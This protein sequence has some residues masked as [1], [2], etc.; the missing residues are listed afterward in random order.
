MSEFAFVHNRW[1]FQRVLDG[2]MDAL[3]ISARAVA[4]KC[5]VSSSTVNRWRRGD[6][7]PDVYMREIVVAWCFDMLLDCVRV[8]DDPHEEIA[9]LRKELDIAL[10]KLTGLG[11]HE[12]VCHWSR[13][14]EGVPVKT[15]SGNGKMTHG[16]GKKAHDCAICLNTGWCY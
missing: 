6:A 7:A 1:F 15:I 5:S 10:D 11:M 8:D 12:C 3:E 13:M 2:T 9:M 4:G 14:A 16:V